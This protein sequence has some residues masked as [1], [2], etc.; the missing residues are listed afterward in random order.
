MIIRA[1]ILYIYPY[2]GLQS[3]IAKY[4]PYTF[5]VYHMRDTHFKH[6]ILFILITAKIIDEECIEREANNYVIF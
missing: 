6:I 3:C 1:A 2:I 5:I 4:I